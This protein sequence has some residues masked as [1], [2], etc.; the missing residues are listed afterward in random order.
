MPKCLNLRTKVLRMKKTSV[1]V[2]LSGLFDWSRS[3]TVTA[4][5]FSLLLRHTQRVLPNLQGRPSGQIV[6]QCDLDQGNSLGLWTSP[7]ARQNNGTFQISQRNP[8]IS[9]DGPPCRPRP[10]H[11]LNAINIISLQWRSLSTVQKRA[12]GTVLFLLF[13]K[14][15]IDQWIFSYFWRHIVLLPNRLQTVHS[16]QHNFAKVPSV[17]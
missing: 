1:L 16:G 5:A 6:G 14:L 17:F 10:S 3:R 2:L 7:V 15:S 9:A 11:F 4:L 12:V 8:T 13:M